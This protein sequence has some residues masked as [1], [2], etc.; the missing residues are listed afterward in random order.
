MPNEQ[1]NAEGKLEKLG[2]RLRRGAAKLHPV[3]EKEIKAVREALFRQHQ[4]E[5]KSD[6]DKT[7]EQER[8]RDR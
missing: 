6:L 3:T 5:R 2:K 1:S 8:D 7:K 4:E